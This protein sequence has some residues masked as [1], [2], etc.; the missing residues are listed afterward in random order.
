MFR[1]TCHNPDKSCCV[2]R[3]TIWIGHEASQVSQS[4]ACVFLFS[5]CVNVLLFSN[6]SQCSVFARQLKLVKLESILKE[7]ISVFDKS[8]KHTIS[9]LKSYQWRAL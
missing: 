3:V 6:K 2:T 5:S 9:E 8:L 4:F 1:Y 7:Q